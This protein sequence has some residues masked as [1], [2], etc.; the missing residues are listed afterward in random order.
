MNEKIRVDEM[1][2]G[3]QLSKKSAERLLQDSNV[4][5]E[6]GKHVSSFLLSQLSLEEQAKAFR[7]IR[8]QLKRKDF[9]GEEW[10]K[11]AYFH[12]EKLK[13]I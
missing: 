11:F 9:P 13:Y 10:K 1:K 12:E 2:D 7:L 6:K 3:I 5:F 8:K 4:L